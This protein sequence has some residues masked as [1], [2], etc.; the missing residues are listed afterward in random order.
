MVALDSGN[1]LPVAKALHETY[2]GKHITI[3][4]DD[5]RHLP[6]REPPLPN[7]GREKAEEAAREV[8]GNAIFPTFLESETGA[9]FTDFNDLARSRGLDAINRQIELVFDL[10]MARKAEGQEVDRELERDDHRWEKQ[11]EEEQEAEM[12]VSL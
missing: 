3:L 4:G 11:W 6:E 2:P 5:D 10:D 8:E 9:E 12:D 7:A 1:L